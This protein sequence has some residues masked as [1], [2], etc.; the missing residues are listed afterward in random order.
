[1]RLCCK[2]NW[3]TLF[4]MAVLIACF[5]SSAQSAARKASQYSPSDKASAVTNEA[6]PAADKAVEAVKE[7][8]P[9][10]EK[11][12]EA[13]KEAAP[14]AE[15][16]VE[17]VKEAAPAA[18]K[19]SDAVK[20][21]A[22]AAEK[23]VEAVKEAAPAADKASD[24]VKEAAPA[25][26]KAVEAVK[27]V[28]PAAEKAVEAVKEAAPA[29]EK[30]VEAVKEAAPAAEKAVEA[31]KEAAP[32]AD[33][34]PSFQGMMQSREFIL[35]NQKDFFKDY[36]LDKLLQR[37][38]TV[39]EQHDLKNVQKQFH[40][41][42]DKKDSSVYSCA[43]ESAALDEKV[44]IAKEGMVQE[45][46]TKEVQDSVAQNGVA[47]DSVV[48]DRMTHVE[49]YE[50]RLQ[51]IYG[52]GQKTD[53]NLKQEH[54]D[55]K[56][57]GERLEESRL[58]KI[59][60]QGEHFDPHQGEDSSLLSAKELYKKGYNLLLSAHYVDAEKAF[61]TFQQHYKKNPLRDDALFWLA[62]AL[63]G[64]KRYHEAAQVYLNAWYTDKKE[65]YSSEILLK[66]AISMVALEQN[67]EVC[68]LAA[69]Q[70][71]ETLESVFCKPVKRRGVG[72][73]GH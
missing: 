70:A 40:Q 7:A 9:A 20:E 39:L 5:T 33:E 19:A 21:A 71:K 45:Q 15:K 68:T 37:I 41:L 61:C 27:E 8:A 25:A 16:A 32:A 67:K 12:V 14:A 24:A 59:H 31:V 60:E 34:G 69:K 47:K 65:L 4:C 1:M 48:Q 51:E 23:A 73:G 56:E 35:Q 66:L 55:A 38:R 54:Q 64:Q 3:K 18:D 46:N 44:Q 62:E 58:E 2:K 72:H 10:A 57:T 17:A 53:E 11:A 29:A 42:F 49:S 30:A 52:H 50:S 26:E 22:P 13:V 43:V 63:L 6:A 28:A 36:D